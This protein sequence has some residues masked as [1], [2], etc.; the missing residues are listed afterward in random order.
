MKTNELSYFIGRATVTNQPSV[1]C[2]LTKRGR[3]VLKLISAAM[4]LGA[5]STTGVRADA[6]T[7]LYTQVALGDPDFGGGSNAGGTLAPGMVQSQLGPDGLPV[8]SASGITRLG[9]SA[10]MNPATHE[11]LWWSAGADPYVSLD[12][13]PVQIDPMPINYGYPNP[14]YPTGQTGDQNFYRTVQWEGTFT[15]ASA[16]S[17]ALTLQVDDDAWVFIDGTLVTENHYGYSS[18]TSTPMSAGT[19]SINVFYDDRFPV[20]D[21]FLLTSSVPLSPVPEPGTIALF[22]AGAIGLLAF[23][24]RHQKPAA[25]Q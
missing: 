11:L 24:R 6:L 12:Q 1:S 3:F 22:I 18:N 5:L 10:D 16:G 25:R 9:T 23:R 2:S 14:W 19:H 15:M 4:L 21:A 13:N 17:I 8:L 7:G 20:Y